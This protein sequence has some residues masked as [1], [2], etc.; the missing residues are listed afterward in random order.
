MRSP[1]MAWKKMQK[2]MNN[3]KIVLG[4]ALAIP[5]SLLGL[6]VLLN[7]AVQSQ[8][9]NEKISLIIFIVFTTTTFY[10]LVRYARKK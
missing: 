2:K 1:L 6:F 3:W 7:A 10:Q 4:L 5:S 8:L 9:I